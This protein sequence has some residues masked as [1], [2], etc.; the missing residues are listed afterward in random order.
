MEPYNKTDQKLHLVCQVLAKLNRTYVQPQYDDSHTNLYFDPEQMRIYS[1]W[2]NTNGVKI[3]ASLNL[4]DS[5]IEWQDEHFKILQSI[6]IADKTCLEIERHVQKGLVQFALNQEDFSVPMH[7]KIPSYSFQNNV[8]QPFTEEELNNW[9]YYRKLANFGCESLVKVFGKS[10][11]IRIWPHHFDTC[12]YTTLNKSFEIKFG[13]AMDDGLADSAYFYLTGFTK[14]GRVN[15][16]E[17]PKLE[18]GKWLITDHWKG[19][20]FTIHELNSI[21]TENH[22]QAVNKFGNEA[23]NWFLNA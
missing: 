3:I 14:M 13:L 5:A 21:P 19:A 9:C 8:Y 2:I 18:N 22:L 16:T 23:L 12:I 1:R 7:Y 20:I 10:V 6:T 17:L 15:F 4:T 11:D